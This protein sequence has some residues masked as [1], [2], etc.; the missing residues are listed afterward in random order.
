[1][2]LEKKLIFLPNVWTKKTV[3]STVN[4]AK[5]TTVSNRLNKIKTKYTFIVSIP[6]K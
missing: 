4:V 2:A 5:D 6:L 3:F 1:M